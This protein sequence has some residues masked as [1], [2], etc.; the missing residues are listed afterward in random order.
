MLSTSKTG[1]NVDHDTEMIISLC[2]KI[3]QQHSS[4]G[5]ASPLSNSMI[6]S[7]SSRITS[8]KEKHSEGTKYQKLMEAAWQERDLYLVNGGKDVMSDLKAIRNTL[9]DQSVDVSSW[10]F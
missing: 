5:P 2:E 8:A 3:I 10:G 7:L 4:L 6:A 1:Q 9:D